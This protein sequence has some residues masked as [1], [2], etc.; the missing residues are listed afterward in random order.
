M[1][2]LPLFPLNTVLFPGMPLELH[3]FEERYKLMIGM[4]IEKRIPFGVVLL[5]QGKAE[6]DLSGSTP[7]PQP[8]LIGCTA[9][10]TQ[11]KPLPEGRMN[12]TVVGRERF[13]IVSIHHDKPY[14]VASVEMYPIDGGD[15]RTLIKST[16][17]LR[18]W[19]ER[20]LRV[21]EK[22][23]HIQFD[24]NQLPTEPIAMAYLGSVLL[25]GI[26]P[27][28]KQQL[29]EADSMITLINQLKGIY[30]R[31]VVLLETLLH[32]PESDYQGPFSLN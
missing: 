23:G 28:L 24:P 14:L 8:F 21:L 5:E 26:A 15:I 10:I 30:R 2:E 6:Q 18:R 31:E 9:Q 1:I 19:I 4:C 13:Q 11:V 27:A 29:L 12:I 3:I 17:A 7:A 25:Q 16:D 32:P 22:A 20:Y